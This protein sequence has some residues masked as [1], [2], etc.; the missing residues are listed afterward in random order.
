LAF[1]VEQADRQPVRLG[2]TVSR[3]VGNAV[4]RNR[5][6][7]LIRESFRQNKEALCAGLELVIVARPS[8]AA[9]SFALVQREVVDICRRA[10]R[11]RPAGP[12]SGPGPRSP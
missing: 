7:R 10:G 6:K 8:A 9:A 5:V 1:L 3:R 4:V 12:S 11:R 2:V